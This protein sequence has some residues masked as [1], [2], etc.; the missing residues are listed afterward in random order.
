MSELLLRVRGLQ[1]EFDQRAA[2]R[3]FSFDLHAGE[4]L[5]LVG[6]SGSG[7]STVARA[8]LRL[9]GSNRGSAQW[10]GE[11]LLTSAPKRMRALRR[12]LQIVFQ[13]PLASLNPRMR[14]A[15]AIAEPLAIFEPSLAAQARAERVNAM[16]E[17]VGL[18]P[19][20]GGRYPHEFSGGQCQRVGIARAMILNPKLL[21]CDEP[22][23]SLDV[24][25]QGQI[26]NLLA[27]LQAEYGTAMFFISHN[28]AVVRYLSRR[29]MVIYMGRCIES[30]ARDELFDKPLHPYSA[31]L[32]A[33]AEAVP[34]GAKP[35][36]APHPPGP[37]SAQQPPALGRP[38]L[39]PPT[40]GPPTQPAFGCAY[41]DRCGYS[42]AA[43]ETIEPPLTEV[44][45]GH[46]AACHRSRDLCDAAGVS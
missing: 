45:P 41:R 44:S 20:M 23:S 42:I 25:I 34:F 16:L 3:D 9:V 1:V 36:T 5:G 21:I 12:D 4:T 39:G 6:E 46:F 37:P 29:I 11:E 38:G 28:L 17:R 32:L 24:S 19:D 2:V 30:A 22:V 26:V 7:K 10:H 31:A 14:I 43:C 40:L 13:N 35:A 15:D 27:D 18:N 8:I 33:A